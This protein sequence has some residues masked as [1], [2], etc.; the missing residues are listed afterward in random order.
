[1]WGGWGESQGHAPAALPPKKEKQYPFCRRLGGPQSRSGLARK[2][3]PP[4]GFDPE[5]VRPVAI[6]YTDWATPAQF[7]QNTAVKFNTVCHG[8]Q[9]KYFYRQVSQ[10][11]N[12]NVRRFSGF[13]HRW[14]VTDRGRQKYWERKPVPVSLYP[15]QIPHEL[16]CDRIH[17]SCVGDRPIAARNIARPPSSSVVFPLHIADVIV[18]MQI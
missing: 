11:E 2:I 13:S 7:S 18:N 15:P 4:P 5:T 16:T 17:A 9:L 3:S 14:N 10:N 1:M 6:R 12:W 8:Y